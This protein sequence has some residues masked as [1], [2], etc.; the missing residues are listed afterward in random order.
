[1]ELQG[2]H[3]GGFPG[4][5]VL[6]SLQA[7]DH[8]CLQTQPPQLQRLSWIYLL[9]VLS[10][11]NLKLINMPSASTERAPRKKIHL[12]FFET[13]CTG[14]H[15]CSGQWRQ[16]HHVLLCSIWG[17]YNNSAPGDNSRTKDRLK[18][19]IDL[20]KLAEKHKITCIFFADSYAGHDVYV[21]S[22]DAVLRAG[23]QVAQLDP[24]A[25]ISAMAVSEF[26]LKSWVPDNMTAAELWR[27]SRSQSHS[28]SQ[29]AL[30]I[31][32][33]FLL[34]GLSALSIIWQMGE[35]HGM[36]LQAGPKPR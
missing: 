23:T 2:F 24:L 18:Y 15:E 26:I 16:V 8:S 14:N 30:A 9:S 29:E 6:F 33:H 19:Y 35:L 10:L 32:P 17:S 3:V 12:N 34:L 11:I 36:W 21:G 22:M 20:A 1:M 4:W 5:C 31:F 28:V 7:E 13:A 25:I 27:L